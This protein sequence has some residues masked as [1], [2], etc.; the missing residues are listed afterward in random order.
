MI[1][2]SLFRRKTRSLL[3]VFGIA[4]GVAAVVA[5]G[6]LAQGLVEG[7]ATIG[8]GSGAD[9]LVT[10]AEAI[11]IVFSGVDEELRDDLRG[12]SGVDDV[13]RMVYTLAATEGAPYFIVFGYDP[14]EFAIDRFKVIEGEPLSRRASTRGGKPLLL[15]KAAASDLDVGVGDTFRLY[16]SAFR[17]MG[18][19]E[20]GEPAEEGS[21]IVLLEDAQL[22][23]GK[24]HQVNALLLKLRSDV[25]LERLRARIE[26][27]F[28]DVTTSTASGFTQDQEMMQYV[29]AFTWSVSFIAILIGGV[30]VMNTMLMSV[31]ER[32]QEFGVLR[33]VGWRPSRVLTMVVAESVLLSLMGGALGAAVG[34]LGVRAVGRVPLASSLIP[35]SIST[36]VFLQALVVA[37]ALGLVGGALPAWRASRL[38]PADAMRSEGGSARAP[39]HVPSATLRNVLRQPT[40]TLLTVV[41]IAI[42]IMAIVLL[43]AMGDGVVNAFSGMAGGLGAHLMG[44]E[45][46]ASVDLSTIDE[47]T[48]RRIGALP[49]VS[50]AEGFLTG[51]TS[52]E[53]LPF[54][55]LFGYQPRGLA[56]RDFSIVEGEPLVST[57]Q[58]IL[59]RVAASNLDLEVGDTLRIFNSNF[60]VVGIY[61][62]G[63][64][65]ED[66]GGVVALRDA[67]RLFGQPHKVSFLSIWLEDPQDADAVIRTIET[68]FRDVDVGKASDFVEDLSDVEAMRSS[69]WAIAAMALVVGGLGMTNTMVMSVFERTRE[70]GVLRALGWRRRRVLAMVVRESVA[71]SLLGGL[72]GILVGVGLG[73]LLNLNPMVRGWLKF[74]YSAG[75]FVQ[76]LVTALLLGVVGGIYPAWRAAGLQPVEALRYE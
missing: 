34:Y 38:T 75:L 52:M 32:T 27:R 67:Q 47:G 4:V 56:I 17:V 8:G 33:A 40:R 21:A 20:T 74:E 37:M 7:Y 10:Q 5:L 18:I 49:G 24:P 65:F 57:R 72:T 53:D 9:L 50:A 29:Y 64:S 73:L 11:D 70:I 23:N 28:D 43:R 30:G 71:L 36:E 60:K 42:A 15:G 58:I 62:T 66:G 22:L 13:A 25:E 76:S 31:F 1:L 35:K 55:M 2:K 44:S 63:I 61:E 41:A 46:E 3:T 16:E 19:F 51:Y 45:A 6:A 39:R 48:V 68:R 69:T 12:F 59:G 54:F 14:D 26:Q